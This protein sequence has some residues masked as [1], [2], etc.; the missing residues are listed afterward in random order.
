MRALLLAL[1]FIL[2]SVAA[3]EVTYTGPTG[4]IE[5][6][7]SSLESTLIVTATCEEVW[8]RTPPA[9][10]SFLEIAVNRSATEDGINIEGP[11]LLTLDTEE[12]TTPD[13]S[14][15]ETTATYQISSTRNVP[16]FAPVTL[17]FDA[18]MEGGELGEPISDSASDT[19]EVGFYG[20]VTVTVD[21][22]IQVVEDGTTATYTF[23]ATNFGNGDATISFEIPEEL[24][25][26]LIIEVPDD[27]VVPHGL[28]GSQNEV[29]IPMEATFDLD[30]EGD[31]LPVADFRMTVKAAS[32]EDSS[33]VFFEQQQPLTARLNDSKGAPAPTSLLAFLVLAAATI[34]ARRRP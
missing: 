26:G 33:N 30:A 11:A 34:L 21:A 4:I 31:V 9:L 17:T 15:I 28:D 16:A 19:T 27:V 6:E 7:L 18:E 23:M 20:A 29:E 2:P 24:P 25:N 1:L 12:C 8:E 13:S 14:T 5:P 10:A 22:P 32:S 3:Y